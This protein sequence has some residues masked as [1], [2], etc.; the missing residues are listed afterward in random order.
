[1]FVAILLT[2]CG[3]NLRMTDQRKYAEWE[4]G[5]LFRNDRVVQAPPAGTVARDAAPVDPLAERPPMSLALVER[6]RERF[7]IFCAPCHGR[8]GDGNGIV[9]QRGFPHP[10]DYAEPR[11][12]SAPDR[13]LYDVITHGHGAMYSY[14]DRVPP[15]D[16]W[17][18]VSY[19]RALQRNQTS[20]QQ[21]AP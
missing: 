19:I 4:R 1:M 13:Y 10:P 14:A 15:R 6:G 16:R 2:G 17:A 12:L 11:L 8:S 9:V 21:A 20:T 5:S 3:Q 18:I 7:G